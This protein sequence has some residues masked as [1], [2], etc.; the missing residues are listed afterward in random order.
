MQAASAG[1]PSFPGRGLGQRVRLLGLPEAE[2]KEPTRKVPASGRQAA[3]SQRRSRQVPTA[4]QHPS[5]S[6]VVHYGLQSVAFTPDGSAVISGSD[7]PRLHNRTDSSITQ[8]GKERADWVTP[9]PDGD[10]ITTVAHVD[11]STK[12]LLWST[13]AR[14]V[15][16]EAEVAD[17]LGS[18][19]VVLSPDWKKLAAGGDDN[20]VRLWPFSLHN[21]P[22]Y[23]HT[24]TP[25]H[26][27]DRLSTPAPRSVFA[28]PNGGCADPRHGLPR[29]DERTRARVHRTHRPNRGVHSDR[30]LGRICPWP[31]RA[32]LWRT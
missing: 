20:S 7:S 11:G 3:S 13:T 21:P 1:F 22:G 28:G 27:P 17:G 26:S 12:L 25:T 2:R 10:S 24:P 15:T 32:R 14:T 19:P 6:Q 31:V 9:S 29:P 18:V 23:L 8:V 4:V 30:D 16:G 5:G